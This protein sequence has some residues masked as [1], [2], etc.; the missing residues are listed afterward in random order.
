M[1]QDA[2]PTMNSAGGKVERVYIEISCDPIIPLKKTL[3]VARQEPNTWLKV[4]NHRLRLF[5]ISLTS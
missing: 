2:V 4:N 3:T 5:I 1:V